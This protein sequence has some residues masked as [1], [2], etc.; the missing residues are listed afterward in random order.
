VQSNYIFSLFA[1][2]LV[3]SFTSEQAHGQVSRAPDLDIQ[4]S[5]AG[6]T[7]TCSQT[8]PT[9]RVPQPLVERGRLKARL[10]TLLRDSLFDDTRGIVNIAREK[11]IKKLANKLGGGAA[12]NG[13]DCLVVE[14]SGSLRINRQTPLP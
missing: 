1:T 8:P 9:I 13:I 2:F 4:A 10:A 11:E 3:F 14:T 5:L 6:S 7:L 12:Q